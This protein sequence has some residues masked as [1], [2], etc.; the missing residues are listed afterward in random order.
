MEWEN[1]LMAYEEDLGNRSLSDWFKAH[2]SGFKPLHRYEG[3]LELDSE[4]LAFSGTDV[5]GGTDF[6]LEILL[7]DIT[8]VH[9][10]WD[11]V[12]T[13]F[14]GRK[15]GDRG[16]PW[17]KPLRLRYNARE[18]EKTIYIF[19]G[20]HNHWYGRRSDNRDIDVL[21]RYIREEVVG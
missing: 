1:T 4:K 21:L 5:K 2:T 15:T 11:E 18:G 13:G 9:L 10:G 8:D 20:F 14:P 12:F 17:N 6:S 16:Y 3:V 7:E 19:A